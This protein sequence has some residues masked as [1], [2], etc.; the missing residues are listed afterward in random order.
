[1]QVAL[2]TC[3]ELTVWILLIK[4]YYS[5]Y[6]IIFYQSEEKVVR[7]IEASYE[8]C[9]KALELRKSVLLQK[10]HE[11]FQASMFDL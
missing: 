9:I 1:M 6:F 2:T 7:E 10:V 11:K 5:N 3:S 4:L 8:K